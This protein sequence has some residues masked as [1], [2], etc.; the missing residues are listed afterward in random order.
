MEIVIKNNN[1]EY[2]TY[3]LEQFIKDFSDE[4]YKNRVRIAFKS[5]YDFYSIAEKLINDFKRKTI[6]LSPDKI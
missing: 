3:T 6:K 2:L 1:N 5:N 4:V